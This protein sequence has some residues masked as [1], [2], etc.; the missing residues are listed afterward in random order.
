MLKTPLRRRSGGEALAWGQ[1]GQRS[2]HGWVEQFG[3]PRLHGVG[4]ELVDGHREGGVVVGAQAE[5][6]AVVAGVDVVSGPAHE[7]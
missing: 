7:R 6:V 3:G 1:Q 2:G 5:P 4:A